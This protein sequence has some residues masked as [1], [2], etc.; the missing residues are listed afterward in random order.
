M[1]GGWSRTRS[2]LMQMRHPSRRGA[3]TAGLVLLT[4]LAVACG[5]DS[6]SVS[7]TNSPTPS[8]GKA[9]SGDGEKVAVSLK[10]N[11][12]DPKDISVEHGEAVTF[13]VKN[14]GQAIHDMHILSTAAEGK[15][16]ISNATIQPGESSSFTATF[17]KAGTLKFQC[18]YHLPDMAGT[19]TVK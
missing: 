16:F 5:A 2:A 1:S 8:V 17:S 10:D 7:K 3:V 18:D 6:Q 14:E 11:A 19:I 12:F 15:D 13:T 9:S 4:A